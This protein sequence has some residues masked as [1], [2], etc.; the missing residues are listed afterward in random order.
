MAVLGILIGIGEIVLGI[1]ILFNSGGEA[2]LIGTGIGYI[3]SGIL[4]IWLCSG[5]SLAHQNKEDIE[6][7]QQKVEHLEEEIKMLRLK[8][9]ARDSRDSPNKGSADQD[10]K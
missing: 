9:I 1:I 4:F 5:V 10:E 3:L 2:V 7:L 6:S 8:D